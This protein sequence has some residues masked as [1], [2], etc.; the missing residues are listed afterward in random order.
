LRREKGNM[1][2]KSV[3]SVRK[4][5]SGQRGGSHMILRRIG[6][7]ISNGVESQDIELKSNWRDEA[8]GNFCLNK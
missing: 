8:G 5:S 7:E 1:A 2:L 3:D 4:P 6:R